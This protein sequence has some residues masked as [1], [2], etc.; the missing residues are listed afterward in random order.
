[1]RLKDKITQNVLKICKENN[2]S[3][4]D[5]SEKTTYT[6]KYLKRLLNLNNS[7]RIFTI[8]DVEVL[9]IALKV[10]PQELI[11]YERSE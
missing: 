11:T 1:M 6:E 5:L 4:S 3:L 7:Q 9:S 2:I 8:N 10:K